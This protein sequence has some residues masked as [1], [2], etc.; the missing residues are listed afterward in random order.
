VIPK[1]NPNFG[2]GRTNFESASK[3][4]SPEPDDLPG[5]WKNRAGTAIV[6]DGVL[7]AQSKGTSSFL[8]VSAGLPA[9]TARL[10]FRVRAP[11]AGEGKVTLMTSP[12]ASE[13]SSVSY[14]VSG[15][16]VWEIVTVELPVKE[17]TGILRPYLPTGSAAVDFDDIVLTSPSRQTPPLD[18]LTTVV[19]D[20]AEP[21]GLTSEESNL[22]LARFCLTGIRARTETT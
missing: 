5:G 21:S 18:I 1:F 20:G 11:Q 19:K 14:K 13:T 22:G 12:G 7:H 8:G 6:S 3:K 9:E 4:K 2:K 15:E 17:K 10:T 16:A